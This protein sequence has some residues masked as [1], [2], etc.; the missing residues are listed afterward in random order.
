MSE[1]RRRR[2]FQI[3]L[4]GDVD[5]VREPELNR[6]ADAYFDSDD[7]DVEVDLSAVTF[8]DS[9]GLAFLMSLRRYA[10]RRG[11]T[12]TL[13]SPSGRSLRLL[14][15]AAVPTL[16][17]IRGGDGAAAPGELVDQPLADG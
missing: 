15:L 8:M 5:L 12:V 7:V 17:E 16:F 3:Y 2:G 10:H 4:A 9:T 6:L 14:E 1:S 13:L 11:G